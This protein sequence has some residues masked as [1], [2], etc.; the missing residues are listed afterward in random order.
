M[1]FCCLCIHSLDI[2]L[3]ITGVLLQNYK[4][5]SV[6]QGGFFFFLLLKHVDISMSR[7][8][9]TPSAVIR[10]LG[11]A[12][13]LSFV[14]VCSLE[15]KHSSL[16]V[17]SRFVPPPPVTFWVSE[18]FLIP[19]KWENT[20]VLSLWAP[21]NSMH[22]IPLT[23]QPPRV[24]LYKRTAFVWQLFPLYMFPAPHIIDSRGRCAST[25]DCV[26]AVR[27]VCAC[28]AFNWRV[29]RRSCRP[30]PSSERSLLWGMSCGSGARLQLALYK[31]TLYDVLCMNI[32]CLPSHK[33]LM[34]RRPVGA[35]GRSCINTGD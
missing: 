27:E 13:S 19:S 10:H 9:F 16:C 14:H 21:L 28:D 34:M 15:H 12:L 20:V 35:R 6:S 26:R 24:L 18:P 5:C 29:C 30:K 23:F 4:T 31:A 25:C 33:L 2:W 1:C 22:D 7:S 11:P 3:R 8:I 17:A 32:E